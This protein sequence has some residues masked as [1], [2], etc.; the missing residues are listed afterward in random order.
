[1]AAMKDPEFIESVLKGGLDVDPIGADE[2]AGTVRGIYSLPE[3][4][5]DRARD[6]LPAPQ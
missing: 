2:L 1:M 6:L 3:S 4:A 5:V